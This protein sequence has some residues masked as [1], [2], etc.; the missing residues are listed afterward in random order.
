MAAIQTEARRTNT[1]FDGGR[2]GEIIAIIL[3]AVAVLV[4]LCLASYNPNDNS[5]M[6]AGGNANRANLVGAVG[7]NLAAVLLQFF[8]VI[9][10]ALPVVLLVWAW[11][12]FRKS[13][14][15]LSFGRIAGVIV[16]LL[17]ASALLSLSTLSPL[18]DRSYE[19]GGITGTLLAGT[20]AGWLNPIG[21][22]V[23][24]AALL[25]TGSAACNRFFLHTLL[26]ASR[27]RRQPLE[28]RGQAVE[29]LPG[30]ACAPRR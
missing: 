10:Y 14:A 12:R 27:L 18:A 20:L 1:S 30:V 2:R 29:R 6:A 28:F 21:T 24:L 9:S 8:G 19:P 13:N 26:R 7:A 15:R 16:I 25:C 5:L 22:A 3:C 23:L 11:R 17:A 4:L